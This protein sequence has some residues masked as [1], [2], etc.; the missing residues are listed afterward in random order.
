MT[1]TVWVRG[2]HTAQDKVYHTDETCHTLGKAHKR[3]LETL[4]SEY[5]EC[6][7]CSGEFVTS[8]EKE[9]ECPY[10]EN[11]VSFLSNHI[12]TECSEL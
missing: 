3:P 6:E 8:K 7:F 1:K 2:Q 11:T 12:P 9:A 10:C 4:T 5:T